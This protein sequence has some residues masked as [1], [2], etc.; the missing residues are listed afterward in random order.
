MLEPNNG[1][2]LSPKDNQLSLQKALNLA[3]HSH[4][5]VAPAPKLPALTQAKSSYAQGQRPI[6]RLSNYSQR[7]VQPL[8]SLA[9]AACLFIPSSLSGRAVPLT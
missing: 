5:S 4:S 2:A 8:A 7:V 3:T 9:N 1:Q 6:T